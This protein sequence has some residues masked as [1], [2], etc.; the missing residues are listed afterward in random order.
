[1]FSDNPAYA[2]IA[3][4]AFRNLASGIGSG[5]RDASAL[6]GFQRRKRRRF[7][8]AIHSNN[9]SFVV[10]SRSGLR[11]EDTLSHWCRFDRHRT[12]RALCPMFQS[13]DILRRAN[14]CYSFPPRWS[15][16]WPSDA[17]PNIRWPRIYDATVICAR[18]TSFVGTAFCS[19]LLLRPLGEAGLAHCRL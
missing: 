1:V 3:M 6:F 16:G 8:I 12:L 5:R 14:I 18:T 11:I 4:W 19:R 2:R 9:A 13:S 7:R 17:Q 10:A 15:L